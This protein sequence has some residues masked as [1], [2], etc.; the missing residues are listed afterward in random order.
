MKIRYLLKKDITVDGI[1]IPKDSYLMIA[2]YVEGNPEPTHLIVEVCW[3]EENKEVDSFTFALFLESDFGVQT[4][5]E[6][7]KTYLTEYL[8]LKEEDVV[9]ITDYET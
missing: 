6:K 7:Q 9:I 1:E 4:F 5:V 8:S 2:S 3:F